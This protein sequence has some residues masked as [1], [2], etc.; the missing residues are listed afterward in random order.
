MRREWPVLQPAG[1]EQPRHSVRMQRERLVAVQS[2]HAFL[3]F[4]L[5][6]R[7]HVLHEVGSVVARP[8]LLGFIPPHQLLAL[9]PR[10]SVGS[11]GGAVIN[12]PAAVGPRESPAMTEFALGLAQ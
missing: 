5:V 6:V 2:P 1:H 3:P 10:L 8:L 12:N 9:A 7:R 4:A 11:G